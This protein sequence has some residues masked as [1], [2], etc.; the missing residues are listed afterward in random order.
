M[1]NTHSMSS[2]FRNWCEH[3]HLMPIIEQIPRGGRQD[4]QAAVRDSRQLCGTQP[5]SGN[6][7]TSLAQRHCNGLDESAD[8]NSRQ[9]CRQWYRLAVDK[10]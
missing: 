1:L 4:N 8:G 7:A 10:P 6:G 2:T 3:N 5:H 9:Q